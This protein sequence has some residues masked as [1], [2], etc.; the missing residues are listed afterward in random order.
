MDPFNVC[1]QSHNIIPMQNPLS[2][3]NMANTYSVGVS[4]TCFPDVWSVK[5]VEPPN[6]GL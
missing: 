4:V 6:S 5:K 3:L 2:V 1:S